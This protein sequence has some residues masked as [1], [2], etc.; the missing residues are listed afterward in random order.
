[1]VGGDGNEVVGFALAIDRADVVNNLAGDARDAVFAAAMGAERIT[2]VAATWAEDEADM[3]AA[4]AE[5]VDEEVVIFFGEEL[6]YWMLD[7]GC[8]IHGKKMDGK[9]I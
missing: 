8:W 6:Y 5:A 2:G 4:R 1:M 3:V 9:K 7:V